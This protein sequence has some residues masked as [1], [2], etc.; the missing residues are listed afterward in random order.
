MDRRRF[1]GIAGIGAMHKFGLSGIAAVLGDGV[2]PTSY[3][4]QPNESKAYGS[5]HFGEWITDRFGLPAY[6]YT[7]NQLTDIEAITPVHKE[8]RSPTDHTHQ[9]GN[10]RL[11]AAVSNYGYVQVRQDEGSPKFLNDYC[12]EEGLYG[13]GIGYL[14]DRKVALGT[15][16]S[17]QAESFERVFGEGYYTKTVKGHGY[18]VEQ[19]ILA[20][21]GD[22]PVLISMVTITNHGEE[23][24]DLR[25]VEYWG[26]QNNQFSYRNYMQASMLKDVAKAA[27]MRRAF[28]SRFTHRFELLPNTSGLIERQTFHGRTKE[29][30][31]LWKEVEEIRKNDTLGFADKL[32]SFLPGATMEDFN[33]PPT[34]LVSLDGPVDGY[35]T[36]AASLFGSSGAANPSGIGAKLNNDLGATG[37]SSAMILE[38]TLKLDP[39]QSK[40]FCFLYGYLPEGFKVDE[41]VRKY[42]AD[43]VGELERTST[44]WKTD[45]IHFSVPAE[46]WVEREVRW[47]NYYVR[48]GITYDSFFREHI[49]S[50]AGIYQ[51]VWGFQGAARDPL[52]HTMPFNFTHPEIVKQVIRYTIKGVQPDGSIPYAIVGSGVPMPERF[53]PSD[54]E[55]WLLWTAAEYVLS[56]RDKS[57]LDEKIGDFQGRYPGSSGR[58][59]GEMLDRSYAHFTKVIGVGRHGLTRMLTG[60]FNDTVVD[61]RVPKEFIDEA[62]TQGESVLNAA[63][64]TYVLEY[65]AR[66]LSYIGDA[67]KAGEARAEADAQRAAVKENWSGRWFRRAWLGPHSG[68]TGE[69]RLWLEPQP[70]AII[71]GAATSEQRKTLVDSINELVRRRSPIGAVMMSR[72]E[73]VQGRKAGELDDGGI[74]PSVNG[75]LIWALALVDGSAAWDEWKKNC[76][77]AHA[78]SYPDIWYGIWSGPDTYNS[79]LSKYP[80]QTMFA[81]RLPDG[82]KSP[83]DWGLN[84]TDFPV[85]NMHIHAWPLYSA[86]KLL[87]VEFTERGVGIT[88]TLPLSDY[89]FS[90]PLLG[91]S[92]SARGYSGWYAPAEPGQWELELRLSD[93]ELARFAQVSVNGSIQPLVHAAKTIRFSGAGGAGTPLRWE[94]S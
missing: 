8:W 55:L 50:Q 92:K 51:Y 69:E 73:N 60:D 44:A 31:E 38:R 26:S 56:T 67:E 3:D 90:S 1:L 5:G 15:Y 71:G 49:I 81:P 79:A 12:P 94:V 42:S 35:S 40:T 87:G 63:M 6:K 78:H 27:A 48:S 16:Y 53:M 82:S 72:S 85:M 14:T 77:A 74:S 58:T 39:H 46:P 52:Q 47:H 57:F 64:A 62:Y 30:E 91:F 32:D 36:D 18:E 17:G 9:I 19:T 65:Y 86:A 43:P 13:A 89:E 34:F 66:M 29:D 80:G 7:C 24:A 93:S 61:G 59:I 22:D 21:F 75:T 54:Q 41:L 68:W 83:A 28:S 25:W 20:P 11:V 84:W 88:P 76:L 33:P 45:G 37:K 2:S 23:T 70:W 4:A 10:D